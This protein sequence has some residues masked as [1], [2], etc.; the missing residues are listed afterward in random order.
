MNFM[1]LDPGMSGAIAVIGD[2]GY[3]HTY[4]MPET[5]KDLWEIMQLLNKDY[6]ITY[7]LIEQLHAL[8]A[9]VEEKM[10]IKRGTIATWKLAQHYGS[11]RM[12]LIAAGIPFEEKIPRTWQKIQGLQPHAGKNASKARAQQLFPDIKCTH[13][14]S[15]ALLIACTARILWMNSHPEQY[16]P[17]AQDE[18]LK[19][20]GLR[21]MGLGG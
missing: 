12:A 16:K 14:N 4:N 2:N 17:V 1:G 19:Q 15:D 18:P 20:L 9:A 3:A 6:A 13:I 5:E 21:G 8:P 11:L 7:S 10:G